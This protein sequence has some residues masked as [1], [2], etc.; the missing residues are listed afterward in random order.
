M[1]ILDFNDSLLLRDFDVDPHTGFLPSKIPLQRLPVEWEH[2]E[3]T[4][5]DAIIV[6]RIQLGAKPDITAAESVQ[7][8]LWRAKARQVCQPYT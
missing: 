5:D 4:L 2:W 3:A 7:S 1:A 8:E 6:S